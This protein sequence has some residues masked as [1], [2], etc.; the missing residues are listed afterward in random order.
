LTGLEPGKTYYYKMII[1]DPSDSIRTESE[2][3]SF[4]PQIFKG[5]IHI[6]EEMPD[7]PPYLLD[8][9]NVF[10][11]LKKPFSVDRSSR[12][13]DVGEDF[14]KKVRVSKNTFVE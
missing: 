4:T 9:D 10:T 2:I 7:G 6:P 12:I 13:F 1:I 5:A 14:A 3:I 11:L 8:Q